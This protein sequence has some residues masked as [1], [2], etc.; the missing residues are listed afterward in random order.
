MKGF[1][2]I[3]CSGK[4]SMIHIIIEDSGL[5]GYV[6][7]RIDCGAQSKPRTTLTYVKPAD[8]EGAR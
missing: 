7:T 5:F 4:A 3:F 8:A 6:D 2:W 1:Y